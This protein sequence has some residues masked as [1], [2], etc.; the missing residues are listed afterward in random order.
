MQMEKVVERKLKKERKRVELADWKRT[1]GYL[2]K[3]KFQFIIS[4]SS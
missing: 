2:N 3:E 4:V 1:N